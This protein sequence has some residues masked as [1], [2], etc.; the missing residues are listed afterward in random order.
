[1]RR[2]QGRETIVELQNWDRGQAAS[3]RLAGKIL[4]L[5]GF[6]D[7]N[8]SH[9]TGGPD[10]GK[11][12]TCSFNGQSWI[13][14]VYFPNGKKTFSEI[15][16]KYTRDLEGVKRNGAAGIVFITNQELTV[17]QREELRAI[18]GIDV[19]ARFY[20]LERIANLLDTPKF[21]GVRLEFLDIEMNREEQISFFQS[22][23]EKQMNSINNHLEEILQHIKKSEEKEDSFDGEDGIRSVERIQEAE[24]EFFEK[25]WLDRHFQLK[26]RIEVLD[27]KVDSE[28]WKTAKKNADKIIKKYGEND[29]GPY[30]DFEWGMLNGKLSAIRWVLGDDWDM[31][32]T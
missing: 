23:Y 27:E 6:S 17:N 20:H 16:H 18:T 30:S 26:Y 2:T 14:A 5:E 24:N 7:V 11:D 21:Y 3:E 28:I 9:P 10:G 15:K 31:L 19:D 8:P 12:F 13:G 22:L 32:D 29:V 4:E 25:I 1:M